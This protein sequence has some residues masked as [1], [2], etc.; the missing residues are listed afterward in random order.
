MGKL[1][2][3]RIPQII[4]ENGITPII[5]VLSDDDYLLELDKKLN[6]EISEYQVDKSLEEL[7]DVMEVIYAICNARGYSIEEL[8][9]LKEKK[10]I[11]RGGFEK[12]LYWEGNI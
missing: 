5:N 9:A 1:V 3:D 7:A 2:R 10:R 8:L 4:R 6:E 12:K 11:S